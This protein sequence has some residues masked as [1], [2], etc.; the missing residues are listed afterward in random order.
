MDRASP[1]DS[2]SCVTYSEI[3][4]CFFFRLFV[5][6]IEIETDVE[7]IDRMVD[8]IYFRDIFCF[9]GTVLK[10]RISKN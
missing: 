1:I 5:S 3:D 6:Y 4:F 10:C 9:A 8:R 7:Q 2:I